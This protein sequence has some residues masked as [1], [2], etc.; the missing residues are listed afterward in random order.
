[1]RAIATVLFAVIFIV[2]NKLSSSYCGGNF[3][4]IKHFIVEKNYLLLAVNLREPQMSL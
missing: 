3:E 2:E 1:M 4:D